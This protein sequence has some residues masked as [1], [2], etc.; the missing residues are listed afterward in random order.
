MARI[1]LA[2]LGFIGS[3]LYRSIQQ[4]EHPGLEIAFVW[5]RT[6]EKLADIPKSL[7]LD[8]LA[9]FASRKP[10][11]IVEASHPSVSRD[12]GEAFLSN[13]DYMPLSVTALADDALRERMIATATRN[14]RHLILP[15]GA[16]VGTDALLGWKH[17]WRD[18]RITFRK[19]P[20]NID[21]AAV[22]RRAEDIVSET[23]I[24][25]GPVR[26]IA[27]LFPR[28]VNTMVTCALATI[29][30][31]RCQGRMIADPSLDHAVAEVEAWGTDGSYLTT[32]KRQPMVGVSGTEMF[33]STLRSV[34]KATGAGPVMDF[35]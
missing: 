16:L 29:G 35:L 19:H 11:L 26:D 10:D 6:R 34:L 32:V 24:F 15:Q 22:N 9:G 17:M 5:N 4:G 12:F 33:Q 28:N 30:L 7:V 14:N 1:G 3:G 8:D 21:L 31:D 2:G 25:E 20:N 18:V 27:P 23:V 13:A